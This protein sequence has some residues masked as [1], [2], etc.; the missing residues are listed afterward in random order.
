MAAPWS[1][2]IG[3]I[4]WSEVINHAPR[5]AEGA[6]KL[7]KNM[8]GE[9]ETA[10]DAP[11]PDAASADPALLLLHKLET[12]EQA[13]QTSAELLAQ[14]AQQNAE[15]VQQL[16]QVRQRQR[17]LQGGIAALAFICLPCIAYLLLH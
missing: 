13:Q 15:L 3:A 16:E 2:L 9:A 5:V 7:W 4:P 8:K 10:Q 12:L 14:L 11:P 17:T 6:R 1:T